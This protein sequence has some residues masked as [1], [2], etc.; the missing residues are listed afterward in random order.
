MKGVFIMATCNDK[1]EIIRNYC[2]HEYSR[3]EAANLLHLSERQISRL[4]LQYLQ[5]NLLPVSVREVVNT[6]R[7]QTIIESKSLPAYQDMNIARYRQALKDDFSIDISYSA[8]Y[9]I[10]KEHNIESPLK[11]NRNLRS[12]EIRMREASAG[13]LLHVLPI[14]AENNRFHL[15]LFDDATGRLLAY[16]FLCRPNCFSYFA[17]LY[18]GFS[19]NGLPNRLCF[20][21]MPSVHTDAFSE[22]MKEAVESLSIT[23]EEAC[24]NTA[25]P[26]RDYLIHTLMEYLSKTDLSSSRF[27]VEYNKK[28]ALR[29]SQ[30]ASFRNA[31]NDVALKLALSYHKPWHMNTSGSFYINKRSY[32]IQ[33]DFLSI[34]PAGSFVML[35]IHNPSVI[36]AVYRSQL[37]MASS[38]QI[39]SRQVY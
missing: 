15:F 17:L 9:N 1:Y 37:Y 14:P 19:K 8:L 35:H 23:Y 36:Y 28:Y 12:P 16:R 29:A 32:V 25:N 24:N 7:H 10:L 31:P 27:L 6:N 20:H 18:N 39:K 3:K 38:E 26:R 30:S 21:L 34:P 33:H 5:G 13:E 11:Q 4:K 2:N 22:T